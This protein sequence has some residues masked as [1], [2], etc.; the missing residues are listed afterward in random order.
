MLIIMVQ[1]MSLITVGGFASSDDG[2]VV[3][4]EDVVEDN[5]ET[6]DDAVVQIEHMLAPVIA[7]KKVT[8]LLP[9][10][11]LRTMPFSFSPWSIILWFGFG[12]IMRKNAVNPQ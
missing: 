6:E 4:L 10:T 7:A 5:G 11:S 8:L 3:P 12:A 2:V 1:I 9:R